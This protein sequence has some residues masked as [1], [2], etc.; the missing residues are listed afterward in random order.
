VRSAVNAEARDSN[1]IAAMHVSAWHF[2]GIDHQP[3]PVMNLLEHAVAHSTGPAPW[4]FVLEHPAQGKVAF[5]VRTDGSISAY[6]RSGLRELWPAASVTPRRLPLLPGHAGAGASTWAHLLG[7]TE[8][9]I[10]DLQQDTTRALVVV[11]STLAGAAAA[12]PLASRA[13]AVLVVADAPGRPSK[14]VRRAIRVLSGA[15]P[16]IEAPWIPALRGVTS[17]PDSPAVRKAAAGVAAAIHE[18]WRD[19]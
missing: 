2:A 4:S 8:M 11:R 12:R 18:K 17:V 16:V 19:N 6:L 10:A 13:G 3:R 9:G 15:S 1:V 14:D 5:L 7:A